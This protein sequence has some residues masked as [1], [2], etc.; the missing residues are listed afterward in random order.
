MINWRRV[1]SNLSKRGLGMTQVATAAGI[2]ASHLQGL[3]RGEV[4]EPPFSVGLKLLDLHLD[5][6]PEYHDDILDT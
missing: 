3:W 4:L 6:C 5:R 2:P 1:V